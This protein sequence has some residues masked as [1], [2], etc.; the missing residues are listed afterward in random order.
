MKYRLS[1]ISEHIEENLG[2]DD[3]N[4]LDQNINDSLNIFPLKLLQ[5]PHNFAI[6][7]VILIAIILGYVFVMKGTD[8]SDPQY[9]PEDTILKLLLPMSKKFISQQKNTWYQIL[10]GFTNL[11]RP[12][13]SP[14][15]YLLLS[16]E[17]ARTTSSCVAEIITSVANK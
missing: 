6:V 11:I 4:R 16:D 13:I 7:I 15:V 1:S 5:W 8:V 14:A 12:P 17:K 3:Q 2:L 9:E 10:T